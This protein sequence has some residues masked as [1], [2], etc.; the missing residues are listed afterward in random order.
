MVA[1]AAFNG[2]LVGDGRIGNA[3]RG[4]T[5]GARFSADGQRTSND[6]FPKASY[7]VNIYGVGISSQ[8]V[9]RASSSPIRLTLNRARKRYMSE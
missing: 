9:A 8:P 6:A 3:S 7:G 4:S 1:A 2:S 5:R